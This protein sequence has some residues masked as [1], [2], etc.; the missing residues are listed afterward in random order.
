[1]CPT[2]PQRPLDAAVTTALELCLAT[3][4]HCRCNIGSTNFQPTGY[5][6]MSTATE[7]VANVVCQVSAQVPGEKTPNDVNVTLIQRDLRTH[8]HRKIQ[9]PPRALHHNLQTCFACMAHKTRGTNWVAPQVR[10][11]T[12]RPYNHV[13]METLTILKIL[14][15]LVIMITI[16]NQYTQKNHAVHCVVASPYAGASVYPSAQTVTKRL[17]TTWELSQGG[18]SGGR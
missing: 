7:M 12:R 6:P 13:S 4:H 14:F 18:A 17:R 8:A 2:R 1:M 16:K 15:I 11:R 9:L 5:V 10:S 3:R